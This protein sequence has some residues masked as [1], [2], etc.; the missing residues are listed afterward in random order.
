MAS[1]DLRYVGF[2]Q[3]WCFGQSLDMPMQ[4]VAWLVQLQLRKCEEEWKA[5]IACT[6]VDK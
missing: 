3:E 6:F 5:Q 2:D 4:A 1:L